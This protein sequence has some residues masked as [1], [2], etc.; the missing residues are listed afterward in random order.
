LE[1]IKRHRKALSKKEFGSPS[2]IHWYF[3]EWQ[4]EGFFEKLWKKGLAD[5][6]E[7]EGIAWQWQ[8]I[9]GGMNKAPLAQ[10]TVGHN[11]TNNLPDFS[12]QLL[13]SHHHHP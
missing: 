10:E 12:L 8:S 9:D 5:Y 6:D 3:L 13:I 1:S 2:A 7:M 4:A 11:P